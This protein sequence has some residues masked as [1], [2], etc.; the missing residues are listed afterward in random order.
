MTKYRSTKTRIE[1][2]SKMIPA[3][4]EVNEE[5]KMFGELIPASS[6]RQDR[7]GPK[8]HGGHCNQCGDEMTPHTAESNRGTCDECVAKAVVK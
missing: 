2:G 7:V 6:H 3:V 1:L 4:R 8:C 5:G